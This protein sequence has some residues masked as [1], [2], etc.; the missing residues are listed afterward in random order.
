MEVKRITI[1]EHREDEENAHIVIETEHFNDLEALGALAMAMR[2]LSDRKCHRID[3]E[4][5]QGR[6]G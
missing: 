6:E 3:I 2:T 4:A 1:T 5:E